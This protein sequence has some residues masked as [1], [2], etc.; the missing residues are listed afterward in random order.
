[1]LDHVKSFFSNWVK[2]HAWTEYRSFERTKLSSSETRAGRLT[3]R[4]VSARRFELN[5]VN[6]SWICMCRNSVGESEDT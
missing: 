5:T 2:F 4:L 6:A 3:L 1:M